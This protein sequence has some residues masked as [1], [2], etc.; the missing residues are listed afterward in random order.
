MLHVSILNDGNTNENND[1]K[2]HQDLMVLET[3]SATPL[4]SVFTPRFPKK[5]FFSTLKCYH[6]MKVYKK[7]GFTHLETAE[8]VSHLNILLATYQVHY[9]KLRKFHWVVEGPDF[10]DLHNL[11]EEEYNQVQK[12]IDEVAERIRV[13]G[14]YPLSTYKE[15]LDASVL[16]ESTSHPSSVQMVHEILSDFETLLSCMI[17]VSTAAERIGDTATYDLTTSF[18]KRMEKRHWMLTAWTKG[19][20]ENALTKKEKEAALEYAN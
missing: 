4:A 16:D 5:P 15:Y 13:F 3:E 14:K 8:I 6:N 2:Y 20:K 17:N 9:Q 10:F 7:L 1:S 18:V 11:F 19:P 12:N